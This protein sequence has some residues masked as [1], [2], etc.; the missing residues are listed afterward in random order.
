M[1][2]VYLL[3]CWSSSFPSSE[4]TYAESKPGF[5]GLI[6]EI[7]RRVWTDP[8]GVVGKWVAERGPDAMIIAVG[9]I[10]LILNLMQ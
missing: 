6:C 7:L 1:F 2:Y 8:S 9:E 4:V 5:E 3:C 10:A